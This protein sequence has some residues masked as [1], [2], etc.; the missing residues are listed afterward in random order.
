VETARIVEARPPRRDPPPSRETARGASIVATDRVTTS[1]GAPTPPRRGTT[2]LIALV[3]LIGVGGI[4]GIV[5]LIV[6][7]I[8]RDEPAAT[9][10]STSRPTYIPLPLTPSTDDLAPTRLGRC[11]R[12]DVDR[13]KTTYLTAMRERGAASRLRGKVAL[14]HFKIASSSGGWSASESDALTRTARATRAYLLEQA[15]RWRTSDLAIDAIEWPVPTTRVTPT[16]RV[17]SGKKP[18]A[19]DSEVFRRTMR[20]LLEES[21]GRSLAVV[22]SDLEAIGYDNAAF[23][24][25]FPDGPRG[26]RD[27]AAPTGARGNAAEL[28][29]ALEPDWNVASRSMLVTHEVLH[30]FGADDLYEVRGVAPDEE[31]DVMNAECDGLGPTT[32]GAT[33]AYAIGWT[34]APPAR[35]YAFSD[36]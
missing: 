15:R 5:T 9:A 17:G 25:S 11:R 10:A 19:Q 32:I 35:S 21:L 30:L 1:P 8:A 28:A 16:L 36:R 7:A 34:D 27:F 13:R 18:S 31:N 4:G 22:V 3:A 29:Y 12:N 20:E 23:V 14:V 33:T 26:I 2:L 6:L 24:V